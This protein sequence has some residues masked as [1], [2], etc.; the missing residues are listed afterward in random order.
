MFPKSVPIDEK[1]IAKL[2][3]TYKSAYKEI[4]SEL[5]TATNFGVANRKAILAQIRGI[6]Q[7]LNAELDPIVQ[8]EIERYYTQGADQAVTQLNTLGAPI[9]VETGFNK[10][11]KD[12]I[13][14]LVSDTSR[15]FGESIQGVNRSATTLL[16]RAVRDQITQQLATGKIGGKALQEIKT[17][18]KGILADQGLDSLI[19]KA[20]RGWSLD[21]YS[22]MLI[23][24][25]SVEARNRGMVNRLAE[26]D[27]DLVQ[28]SSH[29]A[30]DV[31]A[32]W[33][34]MILSVTGN[35]PGYPTVD[36]AEADG[37]FHPNCKHAINVL[38]PELADITNAYNPATNTLPGDDLPEDMQDLVTPPERE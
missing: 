29:G 11:H 32:D 3:D 21:R 10:I 5:L 20:G 13:S 23:R 8:S 18:I 26:N 25:K 17:N 28:V 9:N 30:T 1:S 4:V 33:E 37:L 12:A 19:D 6:L 22:E 14:A 7:D 16:G 38:V 2:T 15:A 36:E 35:T 27:Y 31:C 34:G 24:T